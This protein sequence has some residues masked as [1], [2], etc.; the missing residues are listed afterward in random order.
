M[1]MDQPRITVDW[2]TVDWG[3]V[4]EAVLAIMLLGL[5]DVAASAR[6]ARSGEHGSRCEPRRQRLNDRQAGEH[7]RWSK[8]KS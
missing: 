6:R 4:D 8:R 1:R 7:F 3:R 2:E 5:H